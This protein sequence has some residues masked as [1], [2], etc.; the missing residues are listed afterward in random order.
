MLDVQPRTAEASG[1]VSRDSFIANIARDIDAR[2]PLPFELVRIE[3]Q[4]GADRSPVDVVLLQVCM[5]ARAC[6]CAV[7]CCVV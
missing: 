1:G 2:V 6:V 5:H 4:L 7:V 3:E